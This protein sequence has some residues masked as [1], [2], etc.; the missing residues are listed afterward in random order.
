MRQIYIV[1][2]TQVVTSETHPEGAYSTVS[3]YPKTFDSR[4]YDSSE[5]NP[6]GNEVRALQVAKSEYF[7]RLSTMYASNTPTRVMS[8][9]TLS[10]ADGRQ[11]MVE[12]IGDF[13]DMTPTPEP[14]P[15]PEPTPEEPE[16]LGGN[17]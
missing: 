13:P 9:V 11:I 17:A 5:T 7:S 4:N 12:R 10:R 14:E 6:N 1:N 3:G 2:A 16:A 8:V 15:E